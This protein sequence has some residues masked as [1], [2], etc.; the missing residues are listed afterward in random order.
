MC[1]RES[2]YPR[3]RVAQLAA[4]ALARFPSLVTST[5]ITVLHSISSL[6]HVGA[7]VGDVLGELSAT[8]KDASL[9]KEVLR[10]LGR[11]NTTESKDTAGIA[12]ASKFLV[13]PLPSPP[14]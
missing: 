2:A 1:E 9:L 7:V 13:C 8:H 3:V 14:A 6:E 12:C 4:I 10:E 11:L 5:T